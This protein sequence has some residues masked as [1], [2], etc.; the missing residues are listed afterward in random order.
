MSGPSGG[1][2][3]RG[4]GSCNNRFVLRPDIAK[5]SEVSISSKDS[6][7]ITDFLAKKM[8]L[9]NYFENPPPGTPPFA[10]SNKHFRKGGGWPPCYLGGRFDIFYFFGSGK[11]EGCPNRWRGGAWFFIENRGRT[12]GWIR[13]G[14]VGVQAPRACLQGGGRE[15][16][17]KKKN[18]G[19][20]KHPPG[21][22]KNFSMNEPQCARPMRLWN[23]S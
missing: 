2:L 3:G 15:L 7:A 9:V 8:Q 17:V 18:L 19:G 13:S 6:L 4:G 1:C 12:G 20:P 5:A 16:N 11:G 22:M 21:Y 23:M 10:I 14:G